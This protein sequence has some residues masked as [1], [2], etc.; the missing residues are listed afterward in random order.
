MYTI[1]NIDLIILSTGIFYY[2]YNRTVNNSNRKVSNT[3]KSTLSTDEN[4]KRDRLINNMN[5]YRII[6]RDEPIANT[7]YYHVSSRHGS[8]LERMFDNKKNNSISSYEN[9]TSHE[10]NKIRNIQVN[11]DDTVKIGSNGSKK[12]NGMN[13]SKSRTKKK[14]KT[15]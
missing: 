14:V 8:S 7:D 5:N 1:S 9:N 2:L 10:N 13:N 11:M 4:I 12:S 6:K 15:K 3:T